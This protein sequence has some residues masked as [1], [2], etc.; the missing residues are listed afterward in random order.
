MIKSSRKLYLLY[1]GR[2]KRKCSQCKKIMYIVKANAKSHKRSFCN[3]KCQAKWQSKHWRGKHCYQ[4]IK[5]GRSMCGTLYWHIRDKEGK[6]VREHR[7]IAEQMIGRKLKR[8]EVIHHKNGIKTDNRKVNLAV[9]TRNTHPSQTYILILQTRIRE[10]EIKHPIE[11]K[12]GMYSPKKE[13]CH[14]E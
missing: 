10:L 7:V 5:S 2:V 1:R 9:L 12:D 4:W 11:D 3:R 13:L 14:P 8:R 6:W